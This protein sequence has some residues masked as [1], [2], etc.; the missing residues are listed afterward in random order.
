MRRILIPNEGP[1]SDNVIKGFGV[2]FKTCRDLGVQELTVVVPH[3]GA[4]PR[5]AIGELLGE[6]AA[7]RLLEGDSIPTQDI[8]V[9]CETIRTLTKADVPN[10]ALVFY[11]LTN[12]TESIEGLP[13]TKAIV[14]VPWLE[15]E[16]VAWQQRW[17]ATVPGQTKPA[18]EP[19]LDARVVDQLERLTRMINV[20]AGLAH[21]LDNRKAVEMLKEL[22]VHGVQFKPEEMEIWA[23]RNGWSAKH[24][25]ELMKLAEG[26]AA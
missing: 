16:G 24:A 7:E 22:K 15:E 25:A 1:N 8:I 26:F 21:P 10:T 2:A 9:H 6:K 17:N 18:R 20:S 23:V 12:N 14:Y 13:G 5:T 11:L 4:F 19:A 3:K